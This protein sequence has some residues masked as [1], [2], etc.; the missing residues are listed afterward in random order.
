MRRIAL[1]CCALA[2]SA[3]AQ[4]GTEEE[5]VIHV[6]EE[7]VPTLSAAQ[8]QTLRRYLE[9]GTRSCP[10]SGDLWYYRS[11]LEQKSGTANM[12]KY[13]LTQAQNYG[14]ESLRRGID[15]FKMNDRLLHVDRGMPRSLHDKWALVV[16]VQE[17]QD[18]S[19]P[20]LHF[21]A[22][23]AH[24]FAGSLT[25]PKYGRFKTENVRV[26][27]D[28]QATVRG[29]RE[30]IGWL[31]E[32]A[33]P[34]DLVVV[35]I[36]T[37]GSPKTLDTLGV[38]Y[39]IANDTELAPPEKLYSSSYQMVDFV[40]DLN[41]DIAARRVAVFIDTCH[42]GAAIRQAQTVDNESP[43]SPAGFSGAF[44]AFELGPGRAVL[45]ASRAEEES[46][47]SARIENGYFTHFLIEAMRQ[48][49]GMSTV[50]EIADY[51]RERVRAAVNSD[52]HHAQTPVFGASDQGDAIVLGAP[53]S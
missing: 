49:G 45:T 31:R 22:K 41:R 36:S 33:K 46:F 30:G 4:C 51:V 52:L 29:I 28:R 11:L 20:T 18:P 1:L 10:T 38:S 16:G 43:D 40:E 17:F 19:I 50:K 6:R 53:V 14:S 8:L 39:I 2:S 44:R 24:D 23:D 48:K 13:A 12:A 35:Y 34:D 15:P 32:H 27:V 3:L 37:H 47:E 25:D 7:L 21:T 5:R 9:L 42:S 26:L